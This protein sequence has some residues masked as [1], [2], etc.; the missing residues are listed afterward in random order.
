[1]EIKTSSSLLVKLDVEDGFSVVF[2]LVWTPELGLPRQLQ[3]HKTPGQKKA[4]YCMAG[5]QSECMFAVGIQIPER[6]AESK[7]LS[8][9]YSDISPK[10]TSHITHFSSCG[11][12]SRSVSLV[13]VLPHGNMRSK[14]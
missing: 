2:Q 14:D 8:Q 9:A 13:E 5:R 12:K 1:M 10:R 3:N 6:E 4:P 7:G 11:Q